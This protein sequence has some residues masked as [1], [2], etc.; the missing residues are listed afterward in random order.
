MTVLCA[1][2]HERE[3]PRKK[4]IAK[5]KAQSPEVAK[6]FPHLLAANFLAGSS[7]LNPEHVLPVHR[8]DGGY[9]RQGRDIVP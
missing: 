3:S 4:E 9:K 6:M 1:L 2:T 7:G 8:T 5:T